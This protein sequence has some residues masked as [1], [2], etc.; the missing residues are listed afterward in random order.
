ME[1]GDLKIGHYMKASY[2]RDQLCAGLPVDDS[3][4]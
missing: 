1:G 3:L 2:I 4:R